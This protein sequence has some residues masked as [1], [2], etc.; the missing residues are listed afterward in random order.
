MDRL[1]AIDLFKKFLKNNN[2]NFNEF[3]LLNKN[4]HFK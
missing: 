1:E 3:L 2:I 4:L